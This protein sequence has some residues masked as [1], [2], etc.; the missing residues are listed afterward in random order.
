M[1]KEGIHFKEAGKFE[2]TRFEK[3]HNVIFNSSQEASV[4]VA[5][6]IANLILRKSEL[7]EFCVLG[8]A[9]GSSPIKVYEELVRMHKEE[10]LSFKNV[11]TFNLDEYYPMDKD[12]IQSYFHFMHEHLFNHIDI[13]P[14]NINIPDGKVSSEDLQQYC[15]DYEMKI[16]SYGGLDFQLLGIG[17]TGH[18]GFN[19]PGSHINSGTRSITLDHVTRI[20]AAPSF[21][22]IENV[23][24]KAI[25]MGIG[26]IRNAKRIVLLGWGVSK[27]GIIKQTIE[28]EISSHVPATYLQDHNNTTFVL[29]NEA[30]SELTRV[31]TPWLVKSCVWTEELKLK[32]VVWLSELTG[33]PFLKLTDKDYNDNGM[34]SLLTEEGTAYDLNIKMF[35]KMQHTIT[36][37]PGGKPNSD[38]SHRPER[39]IP[40]KKRVI[41]FSPHP[42]DDVISMGGT[43]DRLVE[44][45]HDVHVAY[46]TSGNIAV[47]NEE[48]LKFAEISMALNKNSSESVNI[49][50][51]LKNKSENDIDSIEV[52]KLKGLI[53]RSESLAA[54]RYLGLKDSNVHFLD[55][56]FYET[57]TIKKNNLSEADVDIMCHIIE[58]IKP[59]QI[60]A[61]GD[62]ADPHGTHK[63]CLDSLFEALRRLKHKDYMNDCWVWLYRGAWHEWDSYQIE[64]AVP[65][66]PD[67]VLKK[68]HA[69]FYHQSQKDGVM[70][71]GD[72]S[73][74]FWVRVEDRNRLT[75]KK[76][77]DLGLAEYAAIEAFKRYYF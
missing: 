44:Q 65:M 57:G 48:A 43:F 14:E 63:V 58:T 51:F 19:E 26:T 16:K 3:I 41:I 64:M 66:S 31:K 73:R 25:T 62:L 40:T 47:S 54:T 33:K 4:L 28:G 61:A 56:P 20:D 35:N 59:H 7:N 21:L 70:F 77:N 15:I 11:V 50:N 71:Q 6:E 24:R 30:S 72:D 9:T 17:R 45:G 69:I 42:D 23:P 2:E 29:D 52:R 46:Q 34:S 39:S 75:A 1:I 60:Y 32:A 67:Q 74:E 18:I 76:Y 37:W 68:R 8:L 13:L 38:D 53:R 36:G 49:I 10:D 22:G 55:L 12:N 5:Q 27:A